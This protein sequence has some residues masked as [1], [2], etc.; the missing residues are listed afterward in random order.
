M[1][2]RKKIQKRIAKVTRKA[3]AKVMTKRALKV[4]DTVKAYVKRTISSKMET[5]QAPPSVLNNSA[6]VPYGVVPNLTTLVDLIGPLDSIIQGVGEGE[7]VGNRIH[8][9]KASFK[10]FV[11][12]P[13]TATSGNTGWASP[14]YLKMFLFKQRSTIDIPTNMSDLFQNGNTDVAPQNIPQDMYVPFNKDKYTLFTTRMFKLGAATTSTTLT[15]NN[16]FSLSKYFNVDIT[17]H[18]PKSIL[19]NDTDVSPTNIGLYAGFLMCFADGRAISGVDYPEF[20][21]SCV[22]NCS[23]KDS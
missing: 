2:Y 12:I 10:G 7:R 18:L 23:Y 6:I 1:V 15:P 22:L 16:D 5:K 19:Y 20:S 13:P 14:R 17:K 4:S 3:V 21:F 11:S 8:P 9:L